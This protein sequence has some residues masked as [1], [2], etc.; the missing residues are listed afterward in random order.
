MREFGAPADLTPIQDEA[1]AIGTA[2]IWGCVAWLVAL[3]AMAVWAV[4]A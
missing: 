3:V 2:L 4:L 1:R